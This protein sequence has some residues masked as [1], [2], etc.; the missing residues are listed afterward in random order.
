MPTNENATLIAASLV[1]ISVRV[2][3]GRIQDFIV[4][5]GDQGMVLLVRSDI[6]KQE[7]CF[8][9]VFDKRRLVVGHMRLDVACRL[10]RLM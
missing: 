5:I 2:L 8:N 7:E 10:V 9:G 6:Q 1:E 4:Q 3:M